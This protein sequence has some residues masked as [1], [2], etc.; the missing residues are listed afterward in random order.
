[1]LSQS[2]KAQTKQPESDLS[3]G[4][5][6]PQRVAALPAAS[7]ENAQHRGVSFGQH[8]RDANKTCMS[9][10]RTDGSILILNSCS[11]A[12][13]LPNAKYGGGAISFLNPRAARRKPTT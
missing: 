1:M 2:Y 6:T 9:G 11:R 13:G 10:R 3:R 8:G 12:E 7:G 4:F 5:V